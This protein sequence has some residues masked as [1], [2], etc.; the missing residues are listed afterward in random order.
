MDLKNFVKAA[1]VDL[2]TG[3]QEAQSDDAIGRFVAPSRYNGVS[4]NSPDLSANNHTAITTARFEVSVL[5]ES[6][7]GGK[8]SARIKVLEAEIGGGLFGKRKAGHV[9]KISFSVPLMMPS[10]NKAPHES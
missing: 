5:A 4:L 1:L 8:A 3:I 9:S 10:N 7:V 6:E 2:L